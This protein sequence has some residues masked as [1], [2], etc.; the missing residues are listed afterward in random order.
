MRPIVTFGNAVAGLTSDI[1]VAFL[2]ETHASYSSGI[3]GT[4]IGTKDG[5]GAPSPSTV[6]GFRPKKDRNRAMKN[7]RVGISPDSVIHRASRKGCRRSRL[8]KYS[9][10]KVR[11]FVD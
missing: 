3:R 1:L 10:N 7:A 2:N 4:A 8:A 11:G 6:L 9:W 5:N